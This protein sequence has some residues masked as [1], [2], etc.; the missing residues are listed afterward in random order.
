M[1]AET[2]P[3]PIQRDDGGKEVRLL[4]VSPTLGQQVLTIFLI[5]GIVIVIISHT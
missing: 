1:M 2:L 5:A 4:H 3:P